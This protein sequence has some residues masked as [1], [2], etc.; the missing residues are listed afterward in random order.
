[1]FAD[2]VGDVGQVVASSL[3]QDCEQFLGALL[4]HEAA[5]HQ[6]LGALAEGNANLCHWRVSGAGLAEM[7]FLVAAEADPRCA[8]LGFLQDYSGVFPPGDF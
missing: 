2:I 3:V 5:S 8:E 4:F 6:E 1:L 7:F